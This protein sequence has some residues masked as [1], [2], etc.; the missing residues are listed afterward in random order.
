MT[1]VVSSKAACE[2][3]RVEGK[4]A[5]VQRFDHLSAAWVVSCVNAAHSFG[6]VIVIEFRLIAQ[7]Y[8]VLTKASNPLHCG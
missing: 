1:L 4:T 7:P 5:F 3:W 6:Q 2:K 8:Y